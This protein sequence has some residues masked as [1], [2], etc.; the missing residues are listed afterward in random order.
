MKCPPKGGRHKDHKVHFGWLHFNEE[1]NGKGCYKQVK[2]VKQGGGVRTN[3]YSIEETQNVDSLLKLGKK[4]FFPKGKSQKGSLKD[5][6]VHLSE[7]DGTEI[8]EFKDRNGNECSYHDF[9]KS[10]GMFASQNYL[11]IKN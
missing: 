4:R 11:Y 1:N 9:L 3:T 2:S 8:M 5:M 7:Y 6:E 10:Y